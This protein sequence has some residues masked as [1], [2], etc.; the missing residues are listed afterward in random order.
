MGPIPSLT[1]VQK[2]KLDYILLWQLDSRKSTSLLKL[3]TEFNFFAVHD[4][5]K[6]LMTQERVTQVCSLPHGTLQMPSKTALIS[7]SVLQDFPLVR[8]KSVPVCPQREET[9]EERLY[10]GQEKHQDL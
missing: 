7:Y 1:D 8:S 4:I 3:L 9:V 10:K 2:H 5:C 6:L